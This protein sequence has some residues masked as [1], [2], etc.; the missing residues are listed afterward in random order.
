[1]V[2]S[3]NDINNYCSMVTLP[4]DNSYGV[5][6]QRKYQMQVLQI[7][8]LTMWKC[9]AR[10][11][12]LQRIQFLLHYWRSRSF[13]VNDVHVIWMPI[14]DFLLLVINN[15]LGGIYHRSDIWPLIALNIPLKIVA[16]PLQM[17]TCYYW[18]HIG[19][20][21]CPIP[22]YHRRSPTTYRLATILHDWHCIMRYDPSKSS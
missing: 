12:T 18:Q 14:C 21:H 5:N 11:E 6:K 15:N 2:I 20:R 17:H 22:R 7:I 9:L 1:V 13:K 4:G 8:F 16:K 10:E 19:N 3:S